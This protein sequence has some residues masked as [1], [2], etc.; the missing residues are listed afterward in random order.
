MLCL[1]LFYVCYFVAVFNCK[2]GATFFRLLLLVASPLSC[3]FL[4]V[5]FWWKINWIELNWI[6]CRSARVRV[7]TEQ[8]LSWMLSVLEIPLNKEITAICTVGHPCET[9]SR[10]PLHV[11]SSFCIMLKLVWYSCATVVSKRL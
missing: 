7:P 8:M 1:P 10:H 4:N 9:R 3:V 11:C 6:W 2:G 5:F